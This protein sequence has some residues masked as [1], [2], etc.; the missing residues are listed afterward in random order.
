MTHSVTF[1]P[2]AIVDLS[3]G[4]FE[5][6]KGWSAEHK[7]VAIGAAA[8]GGVALLTALF[9]IIRAKSSR[10]STRKGRKHSKRDF[11][12]EDDFDFFEAI[13]DLTPE[14]LDE[15]LAQALQ[16]FDFDI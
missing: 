3:K 12:D 9:A 2:K 11:D 5:K 1:D 13:E 4:Y 8:A 10:K 16:D 6:V 15:A 7:N 14:D